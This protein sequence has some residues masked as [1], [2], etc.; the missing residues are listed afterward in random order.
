[1]LKDVQ[2]VY[3]AIPEMD[4][5]LGGSSIERIPVERA[6][7]NVIRDFK[8]IAVEKQEEPV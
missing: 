2:R 3:D 1:M 4:G 5:Y 7:I 8:Q 6:I